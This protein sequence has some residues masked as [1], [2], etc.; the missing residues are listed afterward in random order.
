MPGIIDLPC[1]FSRSLC[2]SCKKIRCYSKWSHQAPI[3]PINIIIL[4]RD[5]I[6]QWD[7]F[8]IY[9]VKKNVYR[10]RIGF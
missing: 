5:I 3:L 10:F 6:N 9:K 1:T 8:T 4:G 2:N 7:F